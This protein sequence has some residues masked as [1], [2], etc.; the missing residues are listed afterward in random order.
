MKPSATLTPDENAIRPALPRG[1]SSSPEIAGSPFSAL[2]DA[3]LEGDRRIEKLA[4]RVRDVADTCHRIGEGLYEPSFG[5]G[6]AA[7]L[8]DWIADFGAH[9]AIRIDFSC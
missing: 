2:I 9:T 5:A 3:K 6:V 1:V 4:A 7:A 8:S